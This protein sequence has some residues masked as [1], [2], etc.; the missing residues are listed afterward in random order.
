MGAPEL[1]IA[2]LAAGASSRMR[3]GDKLLEPV[4]GV[5]LL[6]RIVCEAGCLGT[7]VLVTMA[8]DRP[9][10]RAALAGMDARVI[11]VA[12]ARE[13]IAAS[14]R[15]AVASAGAAEGLMVVLGDMPELD[16]QDF[17]RVREAWDRHTVVRGSTEAGQPG[18]PVIF[19]RRLFPAL[20]AL[21]GDS[22]GRDVLR[23]E[24]VVL[25]PLPGQKAVTDLDTPE[26]WAAWRA[27]RKGEPL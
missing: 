5:P 7:P 10:R 18:Q 1:V 14:F 15:A 4:G 3:G 12:Q 20:A 2:I 27:G 17:S 13:G 6:R 24:D 16:R 26:D 21:R 25:V 22:G 8:P 9:A 19:P 11:E 23:G